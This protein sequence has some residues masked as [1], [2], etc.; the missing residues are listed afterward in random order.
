M[1]QDEVRVLALHLMANNN[2]QRNLI[3]EGWVFGFSKRKTALG[4][5]WEYKKL[6]EVSVYTIENSKE[7]IEDTILHE[8]AHAF[9]GNRN[10]HNKIWQRWCRLLG[11]N[12][13]RQTNGKCSPETFKKIKEVAKYIG[14]CP[15]CSI[16]VAK[17]KIPVREASCGKC[18]PIFNEKYILV[19]T[20]KDGSVVTP[21]S[22]YKSTL[23]P[24]FTTPG[25]ISNQ[26][27]VDAIISFN[28]QEFRITGFNHRATKNCVELVSLRSGTVATCSMK[29]A[30]QHLKT[31]KLT[32]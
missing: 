19:W 20:T 2:A 25:V 15:V 8:M 11:A 10:N 1:T 4:T 23:P 9:A 26:V 32:A 17:H 24:K 21:K 6:I 30:E 13:D 5:C 27:K 18:S 22:R 31:E 28:G 3:E 12:P 16:T 29:L 14:T 7:S